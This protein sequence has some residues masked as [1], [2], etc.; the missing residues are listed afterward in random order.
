MKTENAGMRLLLDNALTPITKELGFLETDVQAAVEAYV[1]WMTPLLGE[2]DRVY[3]DTPHRT[4]TTRAGTGSLR[5]VLLRLLPLSSIHRRSLF[6]PTA[7]G[8]C[9]YFDNGWQ[10]SNVFSTMSYL[11]KLLRCRGLRIV[12]VDDTSARDHELPPA[13]REEGALMFEL[14]VDHDTQWL[15]TER[16]IIVMRDGGPW[17]FLQSG[18]P[19][20]FEDTTR[21]T[22]RKVRDRFTYE[23]LVEYAAALGL[24]PFDEDFYLPPER[25]TAVLVEQEGGTFPNYR[26]Y[27]LAQAQGFEY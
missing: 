16:A 10:G 9:A 24:R 26:E 22:A 8:W 2:S 4:L 21:Y 15:N 11:A 6:V 17:K 5:D 20:P 13:R 12:A 25:P 19:L 14:Y 1:A 23:M 18:N 27:T 3:P 7:S